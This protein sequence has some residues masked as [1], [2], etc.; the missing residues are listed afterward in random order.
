MRVAVVVPVRNGHAMV[1]E[2]VAACLAQ[3]RPPDELVVVDNGSRDDT[4]ALARAAGA[5]VVHEPVRGSFRARNRG[6]KS[7]TADVIAFTDVDCVPNPDWLAELTEPFG[8][9]TVAGVGGAIIQAEINSAPQRW[10]VERQFLDQGFNASSAFLPFFATANVA[11][12]R[13][14]LESLGGFDEAFVISGGD[15]DLTWRVQV[16][17]GGKA[18]YRPEAEVRHFVGRHVTDITARWRRYS[19]GIVLLERRWSAWPG[20]P[21][22]PR[23]AAR[24]KRIWGLPFALAHR[25]A[26]RR[27]LSVPLIDAAVAVSAEFGRLGGHLDA[28]RR[29]VTPLPHENRAAPVHRAIPARDRD[30]RPEPLAQ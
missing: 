10:M 28:W 23:L 11:Y 30:D 5:T 7:T 25:A 15:N 14:T 27:P 1:R 21:E 6:W 20:Y 3:T 22:P 16:L 19:S 24:T 26:T 17:A 2:C 18:V 29:G 4:G 9:P 13:S 12:R 8:D